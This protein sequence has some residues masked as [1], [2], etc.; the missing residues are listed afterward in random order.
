[1]TRIRVC[2]SIDGDVRDRSKRLGINISGFCE[3]AL[4]TM[5]DRIEQ[6]ADWADKLK[7]YEVDGVRKVEF[8]DEL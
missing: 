1:M 3:N 8:P 4:R 2:I 5:C 6:K 7:V